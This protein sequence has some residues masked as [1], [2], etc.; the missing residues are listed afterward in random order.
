M[1]VSDF[2]F[3]DALSHPAS[4]V[5]FQSPLITGCAS[6][7]APVAFSAMT[8]SA[9]RNAPPRVRPVLVVVVTS[10]PH[11]GVGTTST[12]APTSVLP[13]VLMASTSIMVSPAPTQGWILL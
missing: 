12:R 6:L 9:A 1:I 2:A 4:L 3:W 5:S 10:A 7:S 11:A 13:P 8:G